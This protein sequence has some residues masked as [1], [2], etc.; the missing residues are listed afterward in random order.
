MEFFSDYELNGEIL[1]PLENS[2]FFDDK[3]NI[4]L[5]EISE[6][7][8]K[9]F[10]N[11]LFQGELI[12][13]ILIIKSDNFDK[14]LFEK[15]LFKI[16]FEGTD[17]NIMGTL[18]LDDDSE[19]SDD[20]NQS[21]P[22]DLFTLN[23][24]KINEKNY[25]SEK[26]SR[27]FFDE[28]KHIGIY[29]IFK[30]IIVP[31]YLIGNNSIMKIQLML[32]NEKNQKL[33]N[34]NLEKNIEP[35]TFYKHGLYKTIEEYNLLKTFFKEIQ[36]IRPINITSIKQIDLSVESFILQVHIQNTTYSVNF[37]DISLKKSKYLKNT[38]KNEENYLKNFD[39]YGEKI[40]INEIQILEEETSLD[41]QE[42][43]HIAKISEDI[44]HSLKKIYFNLLGAKFP[45]IL[46]PT[47]EYNL[48]I[49][50][51]KNSFLDRIKDP[52]KE[53]KKENK[54]DD[55]LNENSNQETENLLKKSQTLTESNVSNE[56]KFSN[57]KNT[58][59]MKRP[60]LEINID[61]MLSKRRKS[62]LK[63][64]SIV[65]KTTSQFNLK[66]N[67]RLMTNVGNPL[68]TESNYIYNTV[69]TRGNL[70]GYYDDSDDFSIEEDKIRINLI[71]PVIIYISSNL[72]YEN[73]FIAIQIKWINEIFQFLK[74]EMSLPKDIYINE[75]FEI[76]IKVRNISSNPM[77][78]F[79]ETKE[80][81]MEDEHTNKEIL[82][83]IIAQ[84]KFQNLGQFDCNQDKIV[85]LKFLPCK[86]GVADLPNFAITDAIS[87]RRFFIVPTNKIIIKQSEGS[88]TN[89]LNRFMS[90]NL[91]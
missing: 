63:T 83:N 5:K 56:T 62:R 23:N 19:N 3:E 42:N 59:N 74:I 82:P 17:N 8:Y 22:Y 41:E 24:E 34:N 11:V 91:N 51:I 58:N 31:K 70:G 44:F 57:L 16:E 65:I 90:I 6:C 30:Q 54:N 36:I 43:D 88:R 39:Y 28:E 64:N 50:V 21:L 15:L 14:N 49:K 38:S 47:E 40:K 7:S 18:R 85:M 20:N 12:R 4:T 32:K 37:I 84:T 33:L 76:K 48:T 35:M 87:T 73:L 86:I 13:L 81:D 45:V 52:D 29:E 2:K 27:K 78:L 60:S 10:R 46:R 75:F 72:F 26:I 55:N 9:D 25:K 89:E 1:I 69:T 77:N 61:D 68:F 80:S 71:T 66:N 53:S 79:M 67:E